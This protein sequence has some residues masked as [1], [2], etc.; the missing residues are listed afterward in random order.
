MAVTF[1]DLKQRLMERADPDV[2]VEVLDLSSEDI[3]NAFQDQI[4]D[5]FDLL[6]DQYFPIEEEEDSDDNRSE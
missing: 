2:L 6:K 1:Q 4:E 5:R 3:V